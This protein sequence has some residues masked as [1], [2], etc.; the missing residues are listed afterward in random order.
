MAPSV[1]VVQR[2]KDWGELAPDAEVTDAVAA[3]AGP[4]FLRRWFSKE[5][6][7]ERLLTYVVDSIIGRAKPCQP[8]R[9]LP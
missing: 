1:V 7:D 9:P 2:A 8:G 6:I 5:A 4:F 3:I